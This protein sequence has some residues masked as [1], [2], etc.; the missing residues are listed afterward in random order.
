MTLNILIKKTLLLSNF[1]QTKKRL[2]HKRQGTKYEN[3]SATVLKKGNRSSQNFC[4][5]V[6][7]EF[8]P[9]VIHFKTTN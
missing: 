2:R 5:Y 1:R 9:R 6:S 7:K 8:T 3:K 4:T